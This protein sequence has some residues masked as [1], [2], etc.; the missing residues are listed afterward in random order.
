[1]CRGEKLGLHLDISRWKTPA[2]VQHCGEIR[3]QGPYTAPG[4]ADTGFVLLC[5]CSGGP[6]RNCLIYHRAAQQAGHPGPRTRMC[7]CVLEWPR[8]HST[9][10]CCGRRGGGSC[11]KAQPLWEMLAST[12]PPSPLGSL[13]PLGGSCCFVFREVSGTA[14]RCTPSILTPSCLCF[15]LR[16]HVD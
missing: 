1:M 2:Q 13:G 8:L 7:V 11:G 5:V 3:A 10:N 12:G 14:A 9:A 4:G 15:V 16:T 6:L